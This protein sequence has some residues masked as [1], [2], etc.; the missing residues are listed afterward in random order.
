[1]HTALQNKKSLFLLKI[2]VL[3]RN[4]GPFEIIFKERHVD[5]YM[6]G[7]AISATIANV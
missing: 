6:G 2:T 4:G 3:I 1:M 5:I 7:P